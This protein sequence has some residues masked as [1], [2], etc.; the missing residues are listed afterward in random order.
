MLLCEILLIMHR[1][2]HD[3]VGAAAQRRQIL[4]L[5][6]LRSQSVVRRLR[7]IILAIAKLP[8]SRGVDVHRCGRRVL[9]SLLLL[10]LTLAA[11]FL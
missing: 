5:L 8:E 2:H 11:L 7:R 4:R 3:V 1:P 10:L 6:H 9:L